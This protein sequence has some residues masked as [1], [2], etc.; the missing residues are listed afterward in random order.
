[1][2]WKNCW[3]RP[4]GA[5]L[6]AL[7][8]ASTLASC[9]PSTRSAIQAPAPAPPESLLRPC[10]PPAALPAGALN[11]PQ[12]ARLWGRDRLALALCGRRHAALAEF[13]RAL[14]ERPGGNGR[15]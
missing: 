13:A 14:A 5:L 10:E 9:A 7:V 1:M 12:I 11:G 6:T 3:R 15:D 2:I 8:L 4:L